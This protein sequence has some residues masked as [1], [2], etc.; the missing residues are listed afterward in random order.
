MCLRIRMNLKAI[1]ALDRVINLR[2][3]SKTFL[4]KKGKIIVNYMLI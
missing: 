4:Y 2:Q 1:N 3:V